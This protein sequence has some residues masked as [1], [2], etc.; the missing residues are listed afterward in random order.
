[1]N[2]LSWFRAWVT[3]HIFGG[4]KNWTGEQI[5]FFEKRYT[6]KT[7]RGKNLAREIIEFNRAKLIK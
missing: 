2:L 1:M 7:N 6:P 3:F 4:F 5:E